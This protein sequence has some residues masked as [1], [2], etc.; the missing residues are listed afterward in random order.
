MSRLVAQARV[1]LPTGM[2]EPPAASQLVPKHTDGQGECGTTSSRCCFASCMT[3]VSVQDTNAA[4]FLETFSACAL[5]FAVRVGTAGWCPRGDA[6]C[7]QLTLPLPSL[8]HSSASKQSK[9]WGWVD[10]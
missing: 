5:L 1:S 3:Y 9:S 10:M 6:H 2:L 4:A 7:G 8:L